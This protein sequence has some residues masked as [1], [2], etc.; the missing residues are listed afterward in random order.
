LLHSSNNMTSTLWQ[1][2]TSSDRLSGVF[3]GPEQCHQVKRVN[4]VDASTSR[5]P[6]VLSFL[7]KPEE[8]ICLDFSVRGRYVAKERSD[9][10]SGPSLQ[11]IV[12]RHADA[13]TQVL[14]A[15]NIIDR[16]EV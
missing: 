5:S 9:S 11:Y 2:G 12:A 14:R 7:D 8:S 16:Y 10:H 15:Y 6:L 3:Q 4:S 1:G 13:P